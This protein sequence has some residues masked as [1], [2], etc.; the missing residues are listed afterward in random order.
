M[1]CSISAFFSVLFLLILMNLEANAQFLGQQSLSQ[2]SYVIDQSGQLW[3]WGDN[4]YGQ[5]GLGDRINRNT[6]TLVP[7]PSGASKWVL[8]AGGANFTI[9]VADSDKLYTWGLNDKGQIGIGVPD[10][11][12]GVPTRVPQSAVCNDLEMGIR[13]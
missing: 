6:P 8:V 5:L 3:V 2:S 12:Y 4:F 10:G 11:L 7:V 13:L 1:R 9:A